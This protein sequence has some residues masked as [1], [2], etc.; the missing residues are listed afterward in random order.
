MKNYHYTI[1]KFGSGRTAIPLVIGIGLVIATGGMAVPLFLANMGVTAAMATSAMF[2]AGAMLGTILFAQKS[3]TGDIPSM[4]SYP[5]QRSNKGTSVPIIYGTERVAGNIL[6]M[7]DNHPWVHKS[8]G[9]GGKGGGGGSQVTD[10]GNRRSFLI[11]LCEGPAI[12]LKMWR[13]K[14]KIDL[15]SATFFRGDGSADTGI[16][17][18]TGEP[19][20]NYPN[21]CCAFFNEFEIGSG[22]GIPNFTF[23]V[24][25]AFDPTKIQITTPQELQDMEN[26]MSADYELVVD[27]DMTGFDWHPVGFFEG[28]PLFTGSLDGR[29]HTISNLSF[30]T[31]QNRIGIFG[32]ADHCTFQ[33]MI[34]DN[35]EIHGDFHIGCLVG[36][37]DACHIIRVGVTNST[38]FIDQGI[39]G[40][41]FVGGIVGT[42]IGSAPLVTATLDQCFANI[43]IWCNWSWPAW[44]SE[45]GAIGGRVSNTDVTDCWG[46]GNIDTTDDFVSFREFL[47]STGGLIGRISK[48][49][50]LGAVERCFSHTAVATSDLFLPPTQASDVTNQIG[51]FNGKWS[52]SDQIWFDCFFDYQAAGSNWPFTPPPNNDMTWGATGVGPPNDAPIT[53]LTGKSTAEMH[54][55]ATYTNFDFDDIWEI[56]EGNGY[57]TLQWVNNTSFAPDENPAVMIEDLLINT[58]YGAGKDES[59]YINSTTFTEVEDYCNANGLLFS[60]SIDKRKPI[61]DW[62][63]FI[64]SHF[65]GY[66]RM[67]EGKICL[68]VFKND[69]TVFDLTRDD[70]VIEDGEDPPPPVSVKK[71]VY[72]KT[73]NRIEIAWRNRAK[74]YDISIAIAQDETDQRVSGKV[75]KKTIQLTGIKTADLAQET[76]YKMLFDYMYRFNIYNFTLT[77]KNMLLET[78]EVG[79]LSDGG[80]IVSQKIRLTSI[81]EDKNGRGLAIEA[82]EDKSH[83]YETFT[84]YTQD[85]ERE[86]DAAPTLS[87][88]LATFT[89]DLTESAFGI[90]LVPTHDDTNG[91]H[92]Y[93]SYD[94][95]TFELVGQTNIV[96]ATDIATNSSGAIA[97]NLPAHTAVIYDGNESL[98]VNI[99]TVTDLDTSITYD[100]FFSNQRLCKIGNEIIAYKDCVETEIAGIWRITGLIRGL[101]GTEAIAHAV[102]ATFFTINI[103][104]TYLYKDSDVGKTLYFKF[105]TFHGQSI[106]EIADVSS[107]GYTINGKYKRPLPVSLMR[108]RG[109][110]GLGTYETDDVIID[111]EYCSKTAGFNLGGFNNITWGNYIRDPDLVKLN[112]LLEEE[113]G[114]DILEQTYELSEFIEEPGLELLLA[115]RN[116]KNPVIV[117]MT[118]ENALISSRTK[119]ITITSI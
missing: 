47:F 93:Q 75:R 100:Q 106:Q 37:A 77:Y 27:L 88:P 15:S 5:V 58:R 87:S 104:F 105:L 17:A 113:D 9:G 61:V 80:L 22:G 45:I 30:T 115:D 109:R 71:R 99:G 10:Q 34:L 26:N 112:V 64:N 55:Q 98:L 103:D 81:E 7:G 54:Q 19:Y 20:T 3:N 43:T 35:F 74:N 68:G 91:W 59:I 83:V 92:I 40:G 84:Y 38:I 110:E 21:T 32:W 85:S 72:S 73:L 67:S 57:P 60:F 8:S 4:S 70:L 118:P 39:S 89:E 49:I 14:T 28:A 82:I 31:T 65:K 97:S 41:S 1:R 46:S 25:T 51:A 101:F 36:Y 76:A 16:E 119:N 50:G 18:L 44:D 11:G 114:T 108:I 2:M 79:T 78:G 111:F 12:V 69:S 90:S 66:I 13:G 42:I 94:D 6:W 52:S 117:N 102:G 56:D 24:T 96:D 53:G 86:A 116:G 107:I 23:E 95:E 33:N 29:Y 62:I 63:D 48:L